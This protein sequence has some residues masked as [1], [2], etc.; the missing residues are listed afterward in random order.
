VTYE[1]Y[2]KAKLVDLAVLEAFHM[3]GTASMCAVAQVIANRVRSGWGE[4]NHVINTAAKFR[5][6]IPPQ[7]GD[8]DPK[9][10]TFRQF[11]TMVDDIYH[12]TADDTNVNLED[13]RGALVS[14][15]YAELHSIDNDWFRKEIAGNHERHPRIAVVG[16]L[17][18]FG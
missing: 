1:N 15:Y 13:D 3:G 12:G 4:W 5:G 11:L 17:T 18:F 6:T 14:L 9:D 8:F 2:I 10:L 16:Q 7:Q